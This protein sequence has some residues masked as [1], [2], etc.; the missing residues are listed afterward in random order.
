MTSHEHID[1]VLLEIESVC[2]FCFMLVGFTF[3]E[4]EECGD[5]VSPNWVEILLRCTT[6]DKKG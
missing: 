2:L 4:K 5:F 6:Q 1:H 3:M